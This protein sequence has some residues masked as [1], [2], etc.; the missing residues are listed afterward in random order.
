MV[1]RNNLI[2]Q[3]K[4]WYEMNKGRNPKEQEL[5]PLICDI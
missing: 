5:R 3:K 1:K 4:N 2:M